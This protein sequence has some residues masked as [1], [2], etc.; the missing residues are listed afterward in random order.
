MGWAGW[1]WGRYPLAALD[2]FDSGALGVEVGGERAL[3]ALAFVSET[4][5]S[6]TARRAAI[7]CR[8]AYPASK[9]SS[10]VSGVSVM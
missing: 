9:L 3:Q 4:G 1:Q 8:R 7:F 5:T 6:C 2:R 10:V